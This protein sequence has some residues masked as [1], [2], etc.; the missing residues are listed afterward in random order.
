VNPELPS[1][2]A[3][4]LAEIIEAAPGRVRKRLDRNPAAASNW[5]WEQANGGWTISAGNETVQLHLGDQ[6]TVL[7]SEMVSCSCLLSPKCFHLLAVVTSLT[8]ADEAEPKTDLKTEHDAPSQPESDG[9]DV[10]ITDGMRGAAQQSLQAID[11]LLV[12]GARASGLIIQSTL[13]R[14][15]HQSRAEGLVNLSASLI[16]MAEGIQRLRAGDEHADC[17]QLCR[18][19]TTAIEAAHGL[20][21]ADSVPKS[22]LG[23]ARRPF[24]PN[25]LKRLTGVVAEP[26]LTLSGY[27][28]VVTHLI[29]D[30]GDIYQVVETRPGDA[31]LINQAYR[32]GID[33]GETTAS[34]QVI[35]RSRIDVQNLTSSPDGRL[36][37]GGKTRW[38]IQP[39]QEGHAADLSTLHCHWTNDI[40]EQISRVFDATATPE[41]PL[42]R[43]RNLVCVQGTIVAAKGA[44]VLFQPVDCNATLTLG[45][46]MDN[47]AVM[48]RQ[49]LQMLARCPGLSIEIFARLRL[50]QAGWMDALSFR[51]L[52]EEVT[53]PDH[54]LGRCHL[55]LDA[56][57]RHHFQNTQRYVEDVEQQRKQPSPA[58]HNV[59]IRNAVD[60]R[61]SKS[62]LFPGLEKR[63]AAMVI[64]GRSSVGS[65]SSRTHRQDHARLVARGQRTAAG[66]LNHLA[67]ACA[68]SPAVTRRGNVNHAS[69]KHRRPLIL[70]VID[71]YCREFRSHYER[72]QWRRWLDS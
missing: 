54:W 66:L 42:P 3:E 25:A 51:A 40:R 63:C 28:G 69:E 22:Q 57:Q 44:G 20:I 27:A 64:G 11:S 8:I 71:Q 16:R 10:E 65:I 41:Q 56:L 33:L 45:I 23:Y 19:T 60:T 17:D 18:D 7:N 14:A 72:D 35:S 36:G 67:M 31:N 9:D 61:S 32:G 26:I 55:G 29:G 21:R 34:A 15:A 5:Q 2:A 1:I 24:S 48:Y 43:D 38:A 70:A 47:A 50:N 46:A 37:K 59:L 12:S 4:L 49:N 68:E 13:L 6:Q 58:E 53:F 52:S 39:V 30:D 62:D